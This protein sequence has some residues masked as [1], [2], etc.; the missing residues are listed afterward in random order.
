VGDGTFV[1]TVGEQIQ[2]ADDAICGNI[3]SLTDQRDLLSQNVLAHL[4]NLVE[5][6][7]VRLHAGRSDAEF[8]YEAIES[9]LAFVKSKANL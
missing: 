9:G 1:T 3:D 4:R 6:T 5:G 2:S 7:A 8:D